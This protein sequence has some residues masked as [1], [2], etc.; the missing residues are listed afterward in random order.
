MHKLLEKSFSKLIRRKKSSRQAG[1]TLIELLIVIAI[2]GL[3]AVIVFVNLNPAGNL[4]KARDSRRAA[5][6]GQLQ[7]AL[8]NYAINNNGGYPASLSTLVPTYIGA[9]PTDP[10]GTA[11]SYCVNTGATSYGLGITLENAGSAIMRSST[12]TVP[13]TLSPVLT[14]EAYSS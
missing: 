12:A 1:F 4:S 14:C 8:D 6:I 7:T 5:D 11:Y 13:C 3:L 2:L 10:N 9:I